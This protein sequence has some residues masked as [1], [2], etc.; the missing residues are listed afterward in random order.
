MPLIR[1]AGREWQTLIPRLA[2][3][4][5]FEHEL[6]EARRT[7]DEARRLTDEEPSR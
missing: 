6:A 3:E 5:R 7:L 2:A 1:D 4:P